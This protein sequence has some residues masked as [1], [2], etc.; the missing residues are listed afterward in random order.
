MFEFYEFNTLNVM[1]VLISTFIIYYTFC[2]YKKNKEEESMNLDKLIISALAGIMLS[3]TVAYILTGKEET[4]L[5]D[6][7]WENNLIQE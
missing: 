6:N 2:K 5:S 1:V 3:I 4:L 7:Y